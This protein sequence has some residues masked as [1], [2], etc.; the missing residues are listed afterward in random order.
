MWLFGETT[1]EALLFAQAS[2]GLPETGV[3]GGVCQWARLHLFVAS[4][5]ACDAWTSVCVVCVCVCV[6]SCGCVCV[7]VCLLQAAETLDNQ[8]LS[9]PPHTQ[10]WWMGPRG[11]PCCRTSRS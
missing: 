9:L 3:E 4:V 5:C 2:A 10:V 6:C 8:L 7:S 1:V 11:Q